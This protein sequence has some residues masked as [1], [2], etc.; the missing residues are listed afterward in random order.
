MKLDHIC[1]AVR[2]IDRARERICSLLGYVP[3]TEKI[4]NTRQKVF[5]QFLR[6]PDSIDIKLIEPSG[7]DSPLVEFLKRGG[8]LHHI[9]FRTDDGRLAVQE[10]QE[11]GARL[12]AGPQPGEAFDDNDIAFMYLGFGLNIEI[13]DTDSRRGELDQNEASA[14]MKNYK[15][16]QE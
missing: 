4:V 9:C 13:I 3:R 6:K 7:T 2:N 16:G 15:T 12:I 1:I 5:V 14:I 10:L 11:G 8:G